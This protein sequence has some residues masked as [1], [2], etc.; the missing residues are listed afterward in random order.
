MLIN[1]LLVS[2]KELKTLA[3]PYSFRHIARFE[4]CR[5]ISA[6]VLIG[7]SVPLAWRIPQKA[8]AAAIDGRLRLRS[9][10]WQSARRYRALRLCEYIAARRHECLTDL[11][12]DRGD[13]LAAGSF[14]VV[15][16][17]KAPS[18]ADHPSAKRSSTYL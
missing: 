1:R 16:L 18:K 6:S 7:L 12:L 2:K 17:A 11:V 4:K 9:G 3:I 14:P 13:A 8:L 10:L 15:S 5:A